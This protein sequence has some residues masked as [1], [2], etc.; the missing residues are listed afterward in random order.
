MNG[1]E[2]LTLTPIDRRLI[3]LYMLGADE[4][5]ILHCHA[6][7]KR[8]QYAAASRFYHR[9]LW[10]TGSPAFALGDTSIVVRDCA[11]PVP[12]SA[13]PHA[14][15]SVSVPSHAVTVLVDAT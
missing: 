3:D 15:T 14:E 12:S 1:F 8:T 4:R 11:H 7:R 5:R 9:R 13:W 2:T 6:P 10:N